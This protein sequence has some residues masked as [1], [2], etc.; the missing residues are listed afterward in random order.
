M[1]MDYKKNDKLQVTI[2]DIGMQGE[3]IGK[4][5]GYT[6]FVKDAVMGDTVEALITKAKKNYA[7]ARCGKVLTPSPFRVQPPCDCYRPCG[8]CQLQ[9]VSYERQLSMKQ[10]KVKNNL[11]R[12]GG[13]SEELIDRVMEPII[14]MQPDTKGGPLI[15]IQPDTPGGPLIGIQPDTPGGP[16]RY[17]NKAQYPVGTGKNGKPIAGFYAGRTHCIIENTDCLLGPESDGAI[18]K[19]VLSFMEKYH[20]SAY[21]ETA[22]TGIV[23]HILI[24]TGFV[25]GEIMVCLVIREETLPES[26]HL[27]EMLRS[28]P[29]AGDRIVSVGFSINHENTNVIMGKEIRLL[30]GKPY[31]TDYIGDIAFRIS[32]LSFFQVNPVQTKKLYETALAYAGLSGNE[33]V[34]DLYCGIGTIS[35]FLAKKAG[36]V[37]GIEIVPEAVADARENAAANGITNAEFFVGKAE[38]ILPAFYRAHES[39]GQEMCHPHVIVVDPPRKGCDQACLSTMLEMQPQRIVYVS[40]DSATLARDLKFLADGGYTLERIRPADMFPM[41]VHVETVCLLTKKP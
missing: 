24:R 26:E 31:I 19:T 40:C 16:L 29:E 41:T 32:P 37:Y 30:Y 22:G 7:Y 18:L 25:T 5:D 15:G 10:E 38:E 4:V 1:K 27:V 14:G 21:D 11:I 3:G 23:R 39:E 8:G 35:L 34:W 13:F 9:P 28:I 36:K 33:S 17:R 6:L 20:I 12:I 2:T